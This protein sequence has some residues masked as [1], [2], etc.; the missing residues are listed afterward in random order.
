MKVKWTQE[1]VNELAD[2]RAQGLKY[3]V[4]ADIMSNKL[5][6]DLDKD[7]VRLAITN[8]S[9]WLN[10]GVDEQVD[11]DTPVTINKL[12]DGSY[13]SSRT[14]NITDD[15]LKDESKLLKY[16]GYDPQ[17]WEIKTSSNSRNI[18]ETNQGLKHTYNSRISVR[19][20]Q[21]LTLDDFKKELSKTY[22]SPMM[23]VYKDKPVDSESTLVIP[24]FDLHFGITTKDT[25]RPNLEKLIDK[26]RV[27]YDEIVIVSGGDVLHSDVIVGNAKTTSGTLLD[28]TD[29]KQAIQD[30][31][32]FYDTIFRAS[33]ANSNHVK[34]YA[35]PGNHDRTTGEMFYM[36][37]EERFPQVQHE[38][39]DYRLAFRV[40][41][42]GILVA[43]GDTAMKDIALLFATRYT[44][45]W[46]NT[47]NHEVYSGHFHTKNTS[48]IKG[49]I[50]RSFGTPKNPDGYEIKNGY[51][52]N[53]KVSEAIEY[54]EDTVIAEYFL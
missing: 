28:P 18:R 30:A 3:R 27:G 2:L 35:I 4:I 26:I 36:V 1:L 40:G 7:I 52:G 17:E 24:L 44:N 33:L 37:L 43:H 9:E 39:N 21:S 8:H 5:N 13:S 38:T 34:H 29:M 53:R 42:T 51:L 10:E 11:V 19:P 32:S 6:A 46:N 16:H 49:V 25:I 15:E 47:T 20:K 14:L 48:D 12:S 22:V 54:N 23:E 31:R 50:L 45:V 41:N